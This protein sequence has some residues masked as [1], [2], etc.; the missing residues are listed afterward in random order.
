MELDFN[1][2]ESIA[3]QALADA[4]QLNHSEQA[5]VLTIAQIVEPHI[6]SQPPF[7]PTFPVGTLHISVTVKASPP[8][9]YILIIKDSNAFGW[10]LISIDERDTPYTRKIFTPFVAAGQ[11]E[12]EFRRAGC[13]SPNGATLLPVIFGGG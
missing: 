11:Y 7:I 1:A 12:I 2:L 3:E 8:G 9:L 5:C 4:V 13:R 6:A 10:P